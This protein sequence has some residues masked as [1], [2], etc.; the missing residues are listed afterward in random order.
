MPYQKLQVS[1]ALPVIVS[2][3]V[4]I[5]D[6]TTE[7]LTGTA[8]F[9]GSTLVDVGTTFL[10]AG[11]QLNAIVYNTTA[12]IAYYVTAIT[13]DLT[14][15]LSPA[16]AGGATDNYVIYNRATIGAVLYVGAGGN[17]SMLM[18]ALKD[19]PGTVS[20]N[21]TNFVAIPTGAFLP[22]QVVGVSSTGPG[23]H[24]TTAGSIIALW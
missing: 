22:T 4:H 17:I 21:A 18:A 6:P 2:D 8:D 5:P 13:D 10:T 9:T 16:S 19:E 23:G 24:E 11:I 7:V 3:T 14:L 20:V 12:Q 1:Q 15:A